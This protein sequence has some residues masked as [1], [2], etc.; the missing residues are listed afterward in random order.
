MAKSR[1]S[2]LA[3]RR[4]RNN[5]VNVSACV[6]DNSI[7]AES[8]ISLR[9]RTINQTALDLSFLYNFFV[10]KQVFRRCSIQ[11]SQKQS[12]CDVG[13]SPTRFRSLWYANEVSRNV[14]KNFT[15]R[16]N[17]NLGG[18]K[19]S[20]IPFGTIAKIRLPESGSDLTER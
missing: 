6:R 12:K 13:P 10:E 1:N 4:F 16:S 7:W 5:S 2:V 19:E 3:V 17:K 11:T 15:K 14:G 8:A 9:H 18:R 20:G